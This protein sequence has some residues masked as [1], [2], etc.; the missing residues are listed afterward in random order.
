[1]S[2]VTRKPVFRVCDQVRRKPACSVSEA[3]QSLEISDIE[4][5]GSML[6]R[7]WTTKALIRLRSLISAFVVRIWQKQ[8]FSWWGSNY[9]ACAN[10]L[11]HLMTK[12]T[13]ESCSLWS[14]KLATSWQNQQNGMCAQQRL[15]SNW[16]SASLIRV[17]AVG[18]VKAWVLSYPLSAQLRLIRLDECQGWYESLMGAYIILL[19]LSWGGSQSLSVARNVNLFQ[20]LPLVPLFMWANSDGSGET[21]RMRRLTWAFT[22]HLCEKYHFHMSWLSL[23]YSTISLTSLFLNDAWANDP[24]KQSEMNFT[25]FANWR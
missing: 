19:I 11:G 6:S 13:L 15:A 2:L 17:F 10:N 1:M 25:S 24:L 18:M 5:R 4:T 20:K 21:E 8:V 7:Q 9:I 22:G 16:A 12:G 3:S 23:V 14:F